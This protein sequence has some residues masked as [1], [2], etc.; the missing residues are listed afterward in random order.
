[1]ANEDTLRQLL[2]RQGDW[3]DAFGNQV[4]LGTTNEADLASHYSY[5]PERYRVFVDGVRQQI[6]YDGEPTQFTDNP[7]SFSLEPQADGE[8]VTFKTAERY[9]YVVQYII[10][11]SLAFQIN[12]DLQSGDVW[13]VG[14]GDPD[15][16][17]SSDDTPG[18][19]ADGWFVYQNSSDAP[20][21]A[22]LAEYRDGTEADAETVTF[23][24]L[25]QV[26]GRIA[27]RTNW[28]NVGETNLT[29]T[30]TKKEDG[31]SE[32]VNDGVGTV[33]VD[34]GKGPVLGNQR[35]TASVKTG[36][37]GAGSLEFEVGSIG[38]RTLG[39]VTGILR[40]KT[41]DF[42]AT[43]SGTAGEFEPLLAIRVD[44]DRNEVNTQ[45]SVLEPIEFSETDDLVLIANIFDK[46]NILDTNGDPLTDADYSA[47]TELSAINSVL[48]TAS[49][50][51]QVPDDTG[52][53]Q[54]SMANPGGYQVA[55]GSLTAS[56]GTTGPPGSGR[57]SSRARTQKRAIPNGDVAVIM[58]RSDST[59]DINGDIQFE[60]DW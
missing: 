16:E 49:A 8:V 17:N 13:A 39:Q 3:T 24:E 29:E 56:G 37:A 28:Y 6:Q 54:T 59:G 19:N 60:Q 41:F 1:M 50:V 44:P 51:E 52:T 34:D 18:P 23:A 21:E 35:M 57:V 53:A 26:W 45:F 40:T 36:S 7:D 20:A 15:L 33:S 55:Y 31:V 27:G 2:A 47:P 9:R 38:V 5:S 48:Q 43:Y 58:A 10:E 25:P 14:Y 46:E 30:Y 32:Q 4:A 42:A 22:T 12:Q 11:W